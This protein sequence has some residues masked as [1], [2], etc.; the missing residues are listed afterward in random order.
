MSWLAD[1]HDVYQ[2]AYGSV[3]DGMPPLM[4]IAHTTIQAHVEIVLDAS[5]NF[6]RAEVL[7]R[8]DA[9][10]LIPCTERSGGRS[11]S[12][13]AAHPLCDKLQ[14][15]AADFLEHGG[16]VTS[17]FA[18][19]PAEPHRSYHDLL[20]TWTHSTHTHPKLKAILAYVENGTVVADLVGAR[21]LPI[22]SQGHLL[23]EWSGEKDDSPSIFKILP[24]GQQPQDAVVRWRVDTGG[25]QHGC[26][27]DDSLISSW[28]D[29]Y[30]SLQSRRGFCMVT[31]QETSLA[32]QHPAKLRHAADKAKLISSNDTSGFTFRGRFT[33]A[34]QAAGVSFEATQKA[35]NALRWLIE[36]QGSRNGDQVIVAWAAH[37]IEAPNPTELIF[38]PFPEDEESR[39]PQAGATIGH[40]YALRLKQAI[41]GY[42]A[43]FDDAEDVIVMA[44]DAATPGRMAITYYR[45]LP[46]SEFLRRLENWHLAFAWVQCHGISKGTRL[47]F[48]GPPTPNEIAEA[49][50]G[51]S[52]NEKLKNATRAR[53][54]PCIVDGTP[55]PP[56]L[57]RAAC[58]RASN[59]IGLDWWEWERTLGIA[60]ALYK[61]AHPERSYDMALDRTRRS[62][63]Y[64]FG[65]LL[66]IADNLE[67]M[68]LNLSKEG[69]ET[70]AARQMAHFARQPMSSW[71]DLDSQKLPPYRSRLQ[72]AAPDFL[73]SR[74][75]EIQEV[76]NLFD[77]DD[78]NDTPLTG[79]FL[80]GFHCQRS[81]LFEK[82]EKKEKTDSTENTDEASPTN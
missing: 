42:R 61:G 9:T 39:I 55:F 65:R 48:V 70:N 21:I 45:R 73:R 19:D 31:G 34:E 60:C 78:F 68:A 57:V 4:P 28:I 46:G 41:A 80:L 54:L 75:N 38:N 71:L 22:D 11:G 14:Y 62:R 30:A 33:E 7:T 15:V 5:G 72:V 51:V 66:A 27:E 13:P 63:D 35:H 1:L 2:R 17:G 74:Q 64:L 44:L 16:V 43:R 50:Y 36:C 82:T 76:C 47:E 8:A 10:T 18:N 49:A 26:W 37:T 40:A 23:A 6:V 20:S 12:R 79:E 24:P 77:P 25:L 59:R 67:Q 56:D 29:H 52:L 58:Q 53:L 69:R 3:A 81:A 32:E